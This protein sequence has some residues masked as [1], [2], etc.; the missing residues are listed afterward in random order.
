LYLKSIIER[1]KRYRLMKDGKVV[2]FELV[3]SAEGRGYELYPYGMRI[4]QD[5][6]E[7]EVSLEVERRLV[8]PRPYT[9]GEL[10]AT[11]KAR[12]IGRPSTYATII[13][14]LFKRG[15][16][17][18]RGQRLIPT[19]RG[20]MVHE[21]LM[22]NYSSFLGEERTRILERKMDAVE[23]GEKDYQEVLGELYEEMRAIRER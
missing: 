15:Y 19:K 16:V 10:I 11:M 4:S 22:A 12:G 1:V 3:V 14:K 5:L 7:G 23:R 18:E 2:E 20:V 9:Q 13:D 6:G 17:V 21:F 8:S